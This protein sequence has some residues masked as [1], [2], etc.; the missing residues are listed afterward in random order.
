[1]ARTEHAYAHL[2][3]HDIVHLPFPYILAHV[4]EFRA[5]EAVQLACRGALGGRKDSML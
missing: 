2:V 4:H 1:M 3:V 5:A